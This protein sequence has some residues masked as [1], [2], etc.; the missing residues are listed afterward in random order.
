MDSNIFVCNSS[1]YN[2]K[3]IFLNKS[4]TSWIKISCIPEEL[5]NHAKLNFD[6]MFSLHSQNKGEV[7][8]HNNVVKSDRWHKSYLNT[9]KFDENKKRSYMFSGKNEL[10][11]N[12][13]ELPNEFKIYYDFINQN[14]QFNQ[15]VANWYENNNDYIAMHS[16]FE[17]DA[18]DLKNKFEILNGELLPI[19][20]DISILTFN[21]YDNIFNGDENVNVDVDDDNF[22]CR[23]FT[24]KP[25]K[26]CIDYLYKNFSITLE[27]GYIISMCGETQKYFRH[28]I[29]KNNLYKETPRISLSFRNFN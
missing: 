29:K 13:E 12:N 4:Q 25:K 7:I 23:K 10:N 20:S 14:N 26:N 18:D 9:P 1:D 22:Y 19:R 3:I 28:G 17:Y 2:D 8:M 27:H 11:E 24:I 16:D 5:K 6:N 21:L 15:V